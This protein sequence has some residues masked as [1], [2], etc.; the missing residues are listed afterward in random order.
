MGSV[1]FHSPSGTVAL[2][3]GERGYL[4]SLV[5]DT[6]GGLLRSLD[7]NEKTQTRLKALIGPDHYLAKEELSKLSILQWAESYRL[8]FASGFSNESLVRVDDKNVETFSLQLN[9]AYVL[10]SDA[11]KLAARIH[12][13]CELHAWVD[14][15]NR[16]WLADIVDSAMQSRIYRTFAQNGW[17]GV[18]KLLRARDDEPVVMSYSVCDNFPNSEFGWMPPWPEGVPERWSE[19]TE[20]QKEIREARSEEWY[21]LDDAKQWEIAM[22]ALRE[23]GGGLEIKPDN[24]DTFRFRHG[25]TVMD[26]LSEDF[27][28]RVRAARGEK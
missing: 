6:A 11:L 23:S 5:S 4:A 26:L 9:T 7:F 17:D 3:G 19:L 24:W 28:D 18:L 21:D 27:E 16:A 2:W 14:G 13:Q 15:P 12:G 25:M 20:A 8:A 10:G 22:P 1:Y